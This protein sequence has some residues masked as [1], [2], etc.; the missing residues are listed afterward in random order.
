MEMEYWVAFGFPASEVVF[1]L[2]AVAATVAAIAIGN[3][4]S[5]ILGCLGLLFFAYVNVRYGA[6]YLLDYV[7]PVLYGILIA[8]SRSALGW[9][10][11]SVFKAGR[12]EAIAVIATQF[13]AVW[14]TT[15]LHKWGWI[16]GRHWR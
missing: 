12:L 11:P 5:F 4:G 8:F 1:F 15:S 3:L 7:M 14:R 13:L 6:P 9:V 10:Q 16:T 2:G